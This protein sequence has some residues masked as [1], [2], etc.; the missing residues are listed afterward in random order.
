MKELRIKFTKT[1]W[2]IIYIDKKLI[3]L[4]PLIIKVI[5]LMV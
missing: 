3:L 2:E 5:H 4:I 1:F